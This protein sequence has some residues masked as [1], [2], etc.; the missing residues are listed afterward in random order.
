MNRRELLKWIPP[1]VMVVTLPAHAQT[2]LIPEEQEPEPEPRIDDPPIEEPPVEEPKECKKK[3]DHPGKPHQCH[4]DDELPDG[5]KKKPKPKHDKG[6]K[7][8]KR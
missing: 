8:H 4:D 2:S 6:K 1:V 3:C 5:R 7:E